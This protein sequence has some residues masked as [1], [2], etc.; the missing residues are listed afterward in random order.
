M[1]PLFEIVA[2]LFGAISLAGC[3]SVK[4]DCEK[5]CTR[6]F[7][8]CISEVVVAA[9]KGT[10]ESQKAVEEA[11]QLSKMQEAGYASCLK[12]CKKSKGMGSDAGEINK[13]LAKADCKGFAECLTPYLK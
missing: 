8:E 10:V 5:M 3:S 4:V 12:S 13:C 7:K 11:G 6:A 2:M 1:R 9:K